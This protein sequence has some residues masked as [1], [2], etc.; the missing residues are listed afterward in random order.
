[1]AYPETP[2]PGI[3]PDSY[4][5]LTED[6]AFDVYPPTAEGLARFIRETRPERR[7]EAVAYVRSVIEE[8]GLPEADAR[9]LSAAYPEILE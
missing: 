5:R 7:H 6:P 9:R 8:G 4:R 1:M 3:D 2:P